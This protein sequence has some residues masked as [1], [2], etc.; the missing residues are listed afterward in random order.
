LLIQKL[1]AEQQAGHKSKLC[2]PQS[3]R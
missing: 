2:Q 1:Y 3:P